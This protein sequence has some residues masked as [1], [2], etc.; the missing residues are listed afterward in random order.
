M[1][2]RLL[3]PD[4]PSNLFLCGIDMLKPNKMQ[5]SSQSPMVPFEYGGVSLR[6]AVYI[7]GAPYFTRRAI[8]EYLEYKDPQK[9]IDNIISRNPHINNS[10][11]STALKLR[12]V[13]GSRLV[14]RET[15]VYNVVGLQLITFESRQPKAIQYKIAVAKLVADMMNGEYDRKFIQEC[16]DSARAYAK[17]KKLK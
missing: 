3:A 6:E 10:E 15:R 16:I 14:K 12:A 2:V 8:G 11:W 17:R 5:D 13:E 9:A 1:T 7:H 4:F